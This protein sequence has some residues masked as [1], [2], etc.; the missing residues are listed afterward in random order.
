MIG[1]DGFDAGHAQRQ[2]LVQVAVGFNVGRPRRGGPMRRHRSPE[3]LQEIEVEIDGKRYAGWWSVA[4]KSQY[5]TVDYMGQSKS[6]QAGGH[7]PEQTAGALLR[8]LVAESKARGGR[9]DK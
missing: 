8:E 6:T 4:G 9:R 5:V 2:A 1:C 7:T 3:P